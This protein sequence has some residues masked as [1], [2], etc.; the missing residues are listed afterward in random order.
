MA[1]QECALHSETFD[2]LSLYGRDETSDF[3]I[4]FSSA[5]AALEFAKILTVQALK[6]KGMGIATVDIYCHL[7]DYDETD[8]EDYLHVLATA[9]AEKP[10]KAGKRQ[11]K[12][13]VK[14]MSEINP[15]TISV[16]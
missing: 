13:K 2:D 12:Q 14:S 8:S 1:D 5:E 10:P 3:S 11:P 16:A 7:R 4:M 6:V 15:R 9:S